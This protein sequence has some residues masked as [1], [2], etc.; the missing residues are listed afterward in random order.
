MAEYEKLCQY[1]FSITGMQG[2]LLLGNAF[3]S[4]TE[5]AGHFC[6]RCTCAA[7]SDLRPHCIARTQARQCYGKYI[8]AC[9]A[10][11]AFFV[12]TIQDN[13]AAVFGPV[14]L[15]AGD[16]EVRPEIVPVGAGVVQMT[17]LQFGQLCEIARS[18]FGSPGE[19]LP[20]RCSK[21]I[22]QVLDYI[23]E[24]YAEHITIEQLCRLTNS[25]R[26]YLSKRFHEEM[27]MRIVDYINRTRINASAQL[28]RETNQSVVEIAFACG[29]DNQ[30]YFNK[31]F[32]RWMGMTPNQYRHGGA[33]MQA[34]LKNRRQ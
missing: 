8:Y 34:T 17:F 27:G 25:S 31:V 1:M 13:L 6:S 30:S 9:P 33:G 29:F 16:A 26:S 2:G 22:T 32:R 15:S 12:I 28:L 7:C 14:V 20:N 23:Q 10:G 18:M 24:R 3:C 11:Y 21:R 19:Q 5:P 4:A